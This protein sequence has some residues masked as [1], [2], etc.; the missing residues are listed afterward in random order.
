M[1]KLTCRIILSQ[2][3]IMNEVFLLVLKVQNY[4]KKNRRKGEKEKSVSKLRYKER[5]ELKEKDR[6]K[7]RYR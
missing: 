7:R 6:E 4:L 2:R 3:R 1:W 5:R